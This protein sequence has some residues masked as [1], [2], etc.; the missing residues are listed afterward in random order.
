MNKNDMKIS[1]IT[2]CF[3]AAKTI[4][5]T[6]ISVIKQTYTNI[7]YIIIDGGSSDQTT[8][9]IDKYRGFISYYRSEPDDG[10]YDA[11]NKGLEYATGDYVFFLGA[12]DHLISYSV[13]GQVCHKIL[14]YD[15]EGVFY[16]DVFRPNLNDIYCKKFSR[17]KLAVKN[18][19]HQGLFYPRCVY[20]KNKYDL[21]YRLFAD[22]Y[23]NILL[24]SKI[25]FEYLGFTISYFNDSGSSAM[26]KDLNF[27]NDKR[28]I[29]ISMLGY[30]PY[31]YSVLY[32]FL[33]NLV[34]R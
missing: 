11:M 6:I 18:I 21:K 33:R 16:G 29:K 4:E 5:E 13:I 22:Y 19:P 26:L 9:I 12:D 1:I 7:E 8:D 10:I 2:V 30:L 34:K 28:E 17:F 23:Y 14:L 3:N 15:K 25:G 20:K 27:E 31:L 24:F 32:H